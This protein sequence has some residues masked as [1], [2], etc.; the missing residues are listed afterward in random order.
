MNEFELIQAYFSTLASKGA[1]RGVE[2]GIGDDCAILNPPA[3]SQL[4]VSTDTLIAGVHFPESTSAFDIGFKSLAVNLSDLAAMGA[5]PLWFTL[6]IT[7]PDRDTQW[8]EGFCN[9]MAKLVQQTG[10]QLVGGDTTKGPLSI[11]VHVTGDVPIGK[12]LTRHGASVGDDVYVSGVI[13]HGAAGLNMA[14]SGFDAPDDKRFDRCFLDALQRFNQPQPRLGLGLALRGIATSCI[15]IS[16]GLL[17]DLEHVLCASKAGASLKL[18]L[19]PLSDA[20]MKSDL[21]GDK[22]EREKRLLACNAGDDYELCFTVPESKR[23]SVEALAVEQ[24]VILT[25]IGKVVEGASIVEEGGCVELVSLG[26]QHF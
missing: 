26:Y 11:S 9:G 22:S 16:D 2:L 5:Y 15:D 19:V 14:L 13:G 1:G 6:C 20:V 24:S 8:I 3:N 23:E 18:E 12:A 10:I 4:V 21:F 7:L 25:R 17:A